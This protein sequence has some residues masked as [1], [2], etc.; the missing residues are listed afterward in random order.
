MDNKKMLNTVADFELA[1]GTTVKLTLTFYSL[2][3]LKAKAK[4]I[5]ERYNKIMTKGPQEEL[6]NVT[7]LYTAYLCANVKDIESCMSEIEFMQ[8]MPVDREYVGN[9]LSELIRPKKK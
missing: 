8:L 2:Y 3:Q 5:Y 9:I 1:D 4:G 6:E 7:I